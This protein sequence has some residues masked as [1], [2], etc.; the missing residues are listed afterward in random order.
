METASTKKKGSGLRIYSDP[1]ER[2][3]A[4]GEESAWIEDGGLEIRW[5]KYSK[6]YYYRVVEPERFEFDWIKAVKIT[7]GPRGGF[8]KFEMAIR[9]DE[10]ETHLFSLSKSH[11]RLCQKIVLLLRQNKIPILKVTK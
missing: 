5:H 6:E 7:V 9:L 4:T 10:S 1:I 11:K 3:E 2:P 8:Y